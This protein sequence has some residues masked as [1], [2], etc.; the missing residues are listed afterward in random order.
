ML[1]E[2]HGNKCV[3][4]G[5][6]LAVSG[7]SEHCPARPQ[8]EFPKERKARQT[9]SPIAV[10]CYR[11]RQSIIPR[12]VQQNRVRGAVGLPLLGHQIFVPVQGGRYHMECPTCGAPFTDDDT[13]RKLNGEFSSEMKNAIGV[14]AIVVVVGG[15]ALF[16]VIAIAMHFTN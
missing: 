7:Y 1:H 12:I 9:R 10:T 13:V 11:C 5:V 14:A 15:I 6:S 16:A 3:F 4:C 2:F 8:T